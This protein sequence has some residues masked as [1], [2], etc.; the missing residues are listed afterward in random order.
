[1]PESTYLYWVDCRDFLH[2]DPAA[3]RKFFMDAGLALG[4]G[5][6]YPTGNSCVRINFAC[7]QGLLLQALEQWK[8]AYAQ[9]KPTPKATLT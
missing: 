6:L 3:L 1:M 7:E 9:S 4:W 8:Q 5:D 2:G